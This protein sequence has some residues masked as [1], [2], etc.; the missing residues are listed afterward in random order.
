MKK[1]S[2]MFVGEK[3]LTDARVKAARKKAKEYTMSDGGGLR[4]LVN[5]RGQ[6]Y[7][8]FRFSYG[9]RKRIVQIGVYPK[10]SLAE[11]RKKCEQYREWLREGRDP[12]VTR[13]LVKNQ[14]IRDTQGTFDN[15]AAQWLEFKRPSWD[16]KNYKRHESILKGILSPELGDLP[17]KQIDTPLLLSTLRSYE[18]ESKAY[19]R[20][21]EARTTAK[22]IFAWAIGEKL[23]TSNPAMDIAGQLQPRRK[24]QS[25]PALAF[26]DVGPM[27]RTMS[28]SNLDPKTQ[29]AIRLSMLL[30]MRD[31]AVIQA[32]WR[33][34]NFEAGQWDVP[35][36]HMKGR[37]NR[38]EPFSTPLPRQALAILRDLYTR[39]YKGP[40]SFIFA[41]YGKLRHMAPG[42]QRSGLK[43]LGYNVTIHGMR[44]LFTTYMADMDQRKEV[45]D[46]QLSHVVGSQ[47]D[48]A[49]MRSKF[50][51]QRT[52]MLQFWADTVQALEQGRPV[53]LGDNVVEIKSAA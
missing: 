53:P 34:I 23:V 43:Q 32:Q 33:E 41:G 4:V 13:R 6:K 9:G 10:V 37:K 28:A 30:A 22:M 17:L 42:T 50:W 12:Q 2:K 24:V 48:R 27:L 20:V 18:R 26:E 51:P 3:L 21:H 1:G 45:V 16:E 25:H 29:A 11:A 47:T 14:E 44:A 15:V 52:A 46:V 38:R 7:L 49:Y 36:S 35:G 40:D 31:G 5:P 19:A 8:Q 39:T